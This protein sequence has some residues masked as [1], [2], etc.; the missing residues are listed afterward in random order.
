ML[1]RYEFFVGHW[2]Q[3]RRLLYA[4][5]HMLVIAWI[6]LASNPMLNDDVGRLAALSL[7]AG[8]AFEVAR[9]IHAPAAERATVDSYSKAVG[10]RT[11]IVLVLLAGAAVPGQLL[12]ITELLSWITH[13]SAVYRST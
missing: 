8:F 1:M 10:Y 3:K 6:W 9:K 13:K 7:L 2:L 11:S 4:A 12:R 5:W